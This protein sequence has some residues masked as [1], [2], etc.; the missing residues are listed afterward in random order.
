MYWLGSCAKCRGDL[1]ETTDLYGR[2][3]DCYQCG[4]GRGLRTAKHPHSGKSYT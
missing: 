4:H 1:F 3:L 2:Y